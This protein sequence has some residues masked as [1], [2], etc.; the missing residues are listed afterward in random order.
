MD[1]SIHMKINANICLWDAKNSP[2][3]GLPVML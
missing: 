3:D 2:M 1:L